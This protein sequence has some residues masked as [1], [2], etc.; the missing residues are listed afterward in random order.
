MD[1]L[2]RGMKKVTFHVN[3]VTHCVNN[4]I[5]YKHIIMTLHSDIHSMSLAQVNILQLKKCVQQEKMSL[6]LIGQSVSRKCSKPQWG[7][8][9]DTL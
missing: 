5:N 3:S 6:F 2:D 9:A 4:I 1:S 7:I 8:V